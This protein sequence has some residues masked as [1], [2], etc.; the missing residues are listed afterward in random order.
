MLEDFEI[1]TRFA[2]ERLGVADPISVTGSGKGYTLA[3]AAVEVLPGMKLL[4]NSNSPLFKWSE[5]VQQKREL[6]PIEFLLP[7][8][9]YIH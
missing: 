9:A 8:G 6:W 2:H 3:S 1:A 7:G 5:V 4:Q